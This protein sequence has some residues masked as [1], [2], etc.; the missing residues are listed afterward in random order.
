MVDA[1]PPA[2][3][4]P[5]IH[6]PDEVL[7]HNLLDAADEVIYFKDLHSRFI[8]VSAGCARVHGRSSPDELVGLTDFDL[9]GQEHARAAYED[10]QRIIATGRPVVGKIERETRDHRPDSW[11]SSSK[12]P[13]RD[14]DGTIIGTFGVTRD[15][16]DRI[17]AE[18]ALERVVR[19]REEANAEL[20]RVSAEL[21]AVL[22]ASPDAIA[23]YGP[24]LR[25]RYVNPA[26][27]RLWD[28]R[29]VELIGRTDHEV[30]PGAR[31]V[32]PW[33][34]ALLRVLAEGLDEDLHL[35]VDAGPVE[36]RW[37]HAAL[38]AE[39]GPDGT[40][41][42]VLASLRD[43]T[44]T[45]R[46]EEELAHRAMHDEV[47]GL[48]NRRLLMDRLRHALLGL[49]R[50]PGTVALLFV[51]LD[52]FK[53]VNDAHGHDQGDRLLRIVAER[54]VHAARA[55]DTVARLGGDE[56]V[57][58]CEDVDPD[59]GARAVAERVVAAL[60]EPYPLDGL[61][62]E[63]CASVGIVVTTDPD[64]DPVTLLRAADR[65]MYRV[66]EAGGDGFRSSLPPVDVT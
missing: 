21:A 22:A 54:L 34:E 39:P 1:H 40:P 19:E 49:R 16:T 38:T 12:Y 35:A 61:V 59:Q 3:D 31:F 5:P 15:I 41:I 42:G 58:L 51:D 25:Y 65:A 63:S 57:L 8:R 17:H 47:T 55:H 29:A 9:F 64:A 6:L 53:Q 4:E 11:A 13:L 27:E 33:E 60:R 45:K 46:A 2:P 66:K 26:C 10:E 56:F 48:P 30:F 37:V 23:R 7:V 14:A 18:R 32:G 62:V 20:A 50:R 52:R 44:E 43:V 24:D 36:G 28:R